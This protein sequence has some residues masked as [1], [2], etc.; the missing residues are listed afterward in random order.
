MNDLRPNQPKHAYE[1][2]PFL[3]ALPPRVSFKNW[4]ATLMRRPLTSV[5][6]RSL[7]AEDREDLL[8]LSES[9]FVPTSQ[10]VNAADGIQQLLRKALTLR[11]PLSADEQRRVNRVGLI[12]IRDEIKQIQP[13]D[14]AG[15]IVTGMTGMGK[16]AMIRRILECIAPNQVLDFGESTSC[17]W[18]RL[19]QCVYLYLDQPS[20]GSRGALLKRILER[21]DQALGTDYVSEHRRTVNIDSLLVVVAKLL[22]MHRVALVAID[23]NQEST[24]QNIPWRT[25]FAIFYLTLM[26]LGISVVLAGNPLAFEGLHLYS[27]VMRRFSTGGVH[28]LS[29]ANSLDEKWWKAHYLPYARD[30]CLVEHWDI[31]PVRRA[32]LEFDNTAGVPGLFAAYHCEVQRT[33]LRRGGSVATVTEED[34]VEATRSPRCV[35]LMAIARAVRDPTSHA[36]RTYLD[37][38]E[39]HIPTDPAVS[40]SKAIPYASPSNATLTQVKT[41]MANFQRQ[42][43]RKHNALVKQLDSLKNMSAEDIRALGVTEDLVSAMKQKLLDLGKALPRK[44]SSR[45]EGGE[46]G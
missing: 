13:L 12:E 28:R 4:P 46:P 5:P 42:Q 25:E 45:S 9:H 30:F 1:P 34:F 17:G 15:A 27:Q 2:N 7:Q 3:D 38:P 19:R 21:L 11:N 43:T 24:L 10:I 26:N 29:P 8:N 33:A 20:N 41:L 39:E 44:K 22:I 6:W 36:Q 31:D 35:E 32:E 14:G 18:Y 16:T 37:L 23:E 40:A